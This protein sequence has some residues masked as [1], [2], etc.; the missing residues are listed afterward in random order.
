[1]GDM[2]SML[3]FLMMGD[4]SLDFKSLFLMTNMMN[5]DC[6]TDTDSQMNMLLPMLMMGDESS[7]SDDLMMLLMMQSM[8]NQPLGM[9]MLMPHLM[10]QDNEQDSQLLMMV[11]MNSMTGGKPIIAI[12]FWGLKYI[13]NHCF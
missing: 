1:M 9:D 7:N 4:N 8:G 10:S 12:K 13:V 11:L 3:P 5:Q 6:T 2:N